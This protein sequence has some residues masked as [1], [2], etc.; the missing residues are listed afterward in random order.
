MV[1]WRK[2]HLLDSK[3]FKLEWRILE[4]SLEGQSLKEVWDVLC[5][6]YLVTEV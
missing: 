4:G 5:G 6:L 3:A 1:C 2:I